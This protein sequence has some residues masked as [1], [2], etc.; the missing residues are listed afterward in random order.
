[1]GCGDRLSSALAYWVRNAVSSTGARP[2]GFLPLQVLV[3]VRRQAQPAVAGQKAAQF[4]VHRRMAQLPQR[5]IRVEQ[6]QAVFGPREA[7]A[8]MLFELR[9]TRKR[10][11]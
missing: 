4:G 5:K 8:Q 10:L 7:V 11:A 3:A 9:S 1:M 6:V 2:D